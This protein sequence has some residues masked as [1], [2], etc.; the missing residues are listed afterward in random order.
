MGKHKIANKSFL[1]EKYQNASKILTNSTAFTV[2]Q[3]PI[4]E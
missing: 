4:K 2:N 1:Q 3:D